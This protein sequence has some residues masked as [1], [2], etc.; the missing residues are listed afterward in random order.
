MPSSALRKRTTVVRRSGPSPKLI[1]LQ[2]RLKNLG[3]RAG[4]KA[5]GV[6]LRAITVGA[7]VAFALLERKGVKL[8]SPMGIDPALIIGGVLAVFGGKAGGRNGKRMEAAGDGI[9]AYAAA[10]SA[11]RGSVKVSGTEITGGLGDDDDDDD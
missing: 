1:K 8:P 9:L 5:A 10:R 4:A 6:E 2:A 7:P 3:S 11:A